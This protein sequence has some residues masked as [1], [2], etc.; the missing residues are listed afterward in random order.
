VLR[1]EVRPISD[2]T[3]FTG[4][5]VDSRFT[6]TWAATLDLLEREYDAIGGRNLVIEVDVDYKAIRNDGLLRADAVA[7]SPAVRVAFESKHGPISM[8]TDKYR[9]PAWGAGRYPMTSWQHNVR[10]IAMTLEALR[11]VD[12]YGVTKRG[13]QYTGWKALPSGTGAAPSP[14]T[15]GEARLLLVRLAV[16]PDPA[17]EPR[18]AAKLAADP[19]LLRRVWREARAVTHP[20][21]RAGDRTGWDQVEQ[22]ARVLGLAAAGQPTGSA[23]H[24]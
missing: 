4:R 23:I 20:D 13:E 16:G 14:M 7:T 21:R 1:Y 10:A 6:A 24:A 19:D 12:R 9:R 22:A 18:E 11:A 15:V 17:D 2:R 8:A 3:P 5:H